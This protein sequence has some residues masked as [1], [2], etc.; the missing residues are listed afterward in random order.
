MNGYNFTPGE[1]VYLFF[2]P[3]A[4]SIHEQVE[5]RLADEGVEVDSEGR[6]SH[7]VTMKKDRVSEEPQAVRAVVRI[8][9]GLPMPSQ[10]LKDTLEKIIETIFLALI[11]TTFG[12]L[13]AVPISFLAARNLMS[14]VVSP[15]GSLMASLLLAPVGWAVGATLVGWIRQRV[16]DLGDSAGLLVLLILFIVCGGLCWLLMPSAAWAPRRPSRQAAP[17]RNRVRSGVGGSGRVGCAGQV[18]CVCRPVPG[19]EIGRTRLSGQRIV[20]CLR[21]AGPA[22]GT[23]RPVWWAWW[24]WLRLPRLCRRA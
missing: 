17:T 24:C 14:H 6:F 23:G 1:T 15:F 4:A 21:Y 19:R 20:R 11:A 5:L 16:A 10:T 8:R 13:L 7:A 12:T 3:A 9:S 18:G 2:L 22:A